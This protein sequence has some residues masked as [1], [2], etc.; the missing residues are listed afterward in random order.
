ME[1]ACVS[2]CTNHIQLFQSEEYLLSFY[3]C[4]LSKFS[5]VKSVSVMIE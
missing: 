4:Y 2:L 1:N 3:V 5:A